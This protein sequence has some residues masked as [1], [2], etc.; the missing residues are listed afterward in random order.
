MAGKNKKALSGNE[1]PAVPVP[2]VGVVVPGPD[3]RVL[4]VRRG[5]PPARGLWSVPGGSI[6]LGETMFQC[7]MR[8]VWEE[9]RI[10]CMPL[11]VCN[12]VDA[13]YRDQEGAIRF[14]YVIVYVVARWESGEPQAGDDASEASWFSLE[15]IKSLDTP[16]RT[17]ELLQQVR[18]LQ[19]F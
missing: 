14:H 4:M 2:A 17:C 13:I 1:Y 9:T 7:A 6:E 8:E 3:G 5:N 19:G 10:R 15:E 11:R 18:E 12:A 16:G